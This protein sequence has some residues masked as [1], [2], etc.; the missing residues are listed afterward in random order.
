[1]TPMA[2]YETY[3]EIETEI[4][5]RVFGSD[6]GKLKCKNWKNWL[7]R[8][9]FYLADFSTILTDWNSLGS[10]YDIRDEP[11]KKTKGEFGGMTADEIN[12]LQDMQTI[13]FSP[14]SIQPWASAPL[15]NP[16]PIPVVNDDDDPL[17]IYMPD[18]DEDD[19]QF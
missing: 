10:R 5:D 4:V 19:G 18:D 8:N 6:A 11:I 9:E 16:A 15:I 3:K 1:L 17:E 7:K 2:F 14:A 13:Q 12:A